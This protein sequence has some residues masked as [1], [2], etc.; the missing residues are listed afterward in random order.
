MNEKESTLK[1][2]WWQVILLFVAALS[3]VFMTLLSHES[4]LT[5]A[6]TQFLFIAEKLNS[7]DGKVSKHMEDK[8]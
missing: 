3:F 7:I 5:K 1:V 6:E 4:R 2:Q 8:R